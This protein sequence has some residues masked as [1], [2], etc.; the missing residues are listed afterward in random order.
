LFLTVL[1]HIPVICFLFSVCTWAAAADR[2]PWV[3]PPTMR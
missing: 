3:K 2:M 1:K